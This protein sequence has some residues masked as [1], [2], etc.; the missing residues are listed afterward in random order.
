[1][2]LK[3]GYRKITI[4]LTQTICPNRIGLREG[5]KRKRSAE[6]GVL[7]PV[8]EKSATEFKH[9]NHLNVKAQYK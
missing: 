3:Y 1:M 7:V 8:F 6:G 5:K 9:K 4:T 2:R